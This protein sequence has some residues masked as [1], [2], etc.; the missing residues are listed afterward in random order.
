MR[1]FL[2]TLLTLI[3][4]LSLVARAGAS[5]DLE[6]A[7]QDDALLLHRSYGDAAL[8]LERTAA[9]GARR[10]RVNLQW[11]QSMPA[12]QAAAMQRP[13]AVDWDFSRLERLY[14]DAT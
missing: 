7:V 8:G 2:I 9:M 6:L 14:E 11:S 5:A 12:E 10:I 1:P 3:L 13:E 4:A